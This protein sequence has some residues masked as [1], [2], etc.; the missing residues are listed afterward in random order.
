M[1]HMQMNIFIPLT[2][3]V[4]SAGRRGGPVRL[5]QLLGASQLCCCVSFTYDLTRLKKSKSLQNQVSGSVCPFAC[6]KLFGIIS[7]AILTFRKCFPFLSSPSPLF[8]QRK[9]HIVVLP[10]Q[11]TERTQSVM[12]AF[13]LRMCILS[14]ESQ[15]PSCISFRRHPPPP[16]IFHIFQFNIDSSAHTSMDEWATR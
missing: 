7:I 10:H 14:L 2:L 1:K 5:S 6:R 8:S 11:I 12:C 9:R 3:I 4:S 16:Y 13:N 15:G